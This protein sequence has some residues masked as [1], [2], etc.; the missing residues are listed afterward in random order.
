MR[1]A[2]SG[3][4]ATGKSTLIEELA[5]AVPGPMIVEE[6]YFALL[7]EGAAF[8]ARPDAAD[9]QL[10]W[11]RAHAEFAVLRDGFILFDRTP[12]DYL[13]YLMAVGAELAGT[14]LVA[15]TH[16]AL[17]GLDL[18]VF[19]PIEVPDRIADG[20]ESRRLRRSVD[21]VLREMWVD[22]AWGWNLPVLEVSGT[23]QARATQVL[24][25]IG[26]TGGA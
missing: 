24:T 1:I 14:D 26:I 10:L 20:G 2:V 25:R 13:A 19:V 9:Y 21:R 11:E 7:A 12:A 6:A 3:S 22:D 16:R 23:P 18:V 8:A 17:V 5:N 15:Q 4:H